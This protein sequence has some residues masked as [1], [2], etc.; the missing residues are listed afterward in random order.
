MKVSEVNVLE[1]PDSYNFMWLEGSEEC[2][3][4]DIK[5]IKVGFGG[6]ITAEITVYIL[7]GDRNTLE[8][9]RFNLQSARERR[10]I[11]QRLYE[12]GGLI[13]PETWL[14][15]IDQVSVE[16]LKR[17][18]QVETAISLKDIPERE[19]PRYRLYPLVFDSEINV[20]FGDGDTGKTILGCIIAVLV[21][22]AYS[23]LNLTPEPGNVLFLDWETSSHQIKETVTAIRKGLGIVRQANDPDILYM[24]CDQLLA[25]T[26]EGIRTTVT[27]ND[28][29][30]IV[31][32]SIGLAIG[33]DA[34]QM[35]SA[36][37]G[38]TALRSL[39]ITTLGIDHLSKGSDGKSPY[40]SVYRRNI[41]RNQFLVRH[42][43]APDV[44]ELNLALIHKKCNIAPKIKPQ[45]MRLNFTM[46]GSGVLAEI[47]ISPLDILDNPELAASLTLTERIKGLLRRGAM[48]TSEIAEELDLV[49]SEGS[50]RTILN[51][52]KHTFIKV[53]D[54][55]G[56]TSYET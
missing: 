22:D 42:D 26:I 40:G 3:A 51:R 27:E 23:V 29:K 11:A 45:G 46:N 49:D 14:Q 33:G 39:N 48:K 30:L 18:R 9:I 19:T 16:T 13:E 25:T 34:D 47:G 56:L 4:I 17:Y 32:D 35:E 41:P 28:I 2:L 15:I 55:W 43:Q 38:F 37:I 6:S 20:L 50:I 54:K 44:Y 24:R 1:Y 8:C 21:Q 5:H 52:A 31:V 12:L 36:R 7:L 53:E 10:D